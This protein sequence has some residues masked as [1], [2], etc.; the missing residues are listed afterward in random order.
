MHTLLI[1][2]ILYL[3][4][5]GV[6]Q[7]KVTILTLARYMRRSKSQMKIDL[8]PLAESGLVKVYEEFGGGNY[9]RYKIALSAQG[10]EHLDENWDAAM[11]IY[12]KHV[13]ETIA[14]I[15]E[16]NS[17]KYENTE[18]RLS[19]KQIEALAAGQGELF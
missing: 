10:Q 8:L 12:Q 16:R 18:K 2:Y 7:G 5:G 15:K 9:K 19:K 3:E 17:G 13:A 6:G 4:L 1:L 11:L 14:I